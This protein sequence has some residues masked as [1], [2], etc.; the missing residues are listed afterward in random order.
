M[1]ENY[2]IWLEEAEWDLENAEILYKNKRYN[3]AVFHAQ[4]ASEKAVK[5]LLASQNINGWGHSIV[6][7]LSKYHKEFNREI[8]NIIKFAMFL[9]KH[10]ILTRYP[11]ALPGI[12][13]HNAYNKEEAEVSINQAKKI[14][15]F[16]KK[17][18]KYFEKL[19][20]EK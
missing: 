13:P 15:D 19:K 3:T 1:K 8:E 5:A 4:Q 17:E 14:I 12:A 18:I 2:K 6:N 16:V 11:D 7:L 10:Y 20:K 9:D